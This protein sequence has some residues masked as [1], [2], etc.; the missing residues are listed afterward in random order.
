MI[1][2]DYRAWDECP[3]DPAIDFRMSKSKANRYR[4]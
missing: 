3:P 1:S 2:D 4:V